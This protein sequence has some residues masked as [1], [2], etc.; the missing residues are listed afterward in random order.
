MPR[1]GVKPLQIDDHP[2][3]PRA[4]HESSHVVLPTQ[5]PGAAA[6]GQIQGR[7]GR[8]SFGPPPGLVQ[9]CRQPHF[10]EDIEGIVA[11]RAVSAEADRH[12]LLQEPGYRRHPG[13]QLG[14][15]SI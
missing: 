12:A 13:A 8:Y 4:R 15:R 3:G 5:G 14:A 10:A 1:C 2:V 9:Q 11:R 7:A 6:S